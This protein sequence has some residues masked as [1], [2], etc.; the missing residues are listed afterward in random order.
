MLAGQADVEIA[1]GDENHAIHR[2]RGEVL[3]RGL[4]REL[5]PFAA[6]RA[7]ARFETFQRP[8]DRRLVAPEVDGST[9][10]L[11]PA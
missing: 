5:N 7:A 2:L 10:P 1:V 11:E 4:V 8:E 3:T 6:V 9:I